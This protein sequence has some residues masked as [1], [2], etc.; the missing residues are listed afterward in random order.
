MLKR[1]ISLMITILILAQTVFVSGAATTLEELESE[2]L[3]SY[4]ENVASA[5]AAFAQS[6]R[7]DESDN[8]TDADIS[9]IMSMVF[10]ENPELFCLSHSYT[11]TY[12]RDQITGEALVRDVIFDYSMT[13]EEYGV[14]LTEVNAWVDNVTSLGDPAFSDY[15]WALFFHDY[16]CANYEYDGTLSSRSVYSFIKTGRGVCQAYAYAYMMLLERVGV[17]ASWASSAEMNHLWNLVKIDGEWYHV[18]VTWDDPVGIVP[19]V[20]RHGYFL[21]SDVAIST[22]A[23]AH[24]GWVSSYACTSDKYDAN[25]SSQAQSAYAYADG[26]W[27][28]VKDGDLYETQSPETEGKLF[29]ELDLMWFKWNSENTYYTGMYSAVVSFG[30]KLYV[31]TPD[32]ILRVDPATGKRKQAFN[33]SG[34]AGRVY[35]FSIDMGED[36]VSGAGLAGAAVLVNIAKSSSEEGVTVPAKLTFVMTGG[37]GDANGDGIVNLSDAS[38]ILKFI[39]KWDVKPDEVA[40]DTNND[41]IINVTDVSNILRYIVS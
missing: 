13:K 26:K 19:G 10:N 14:A 5:A 33:Y 28:F 30:G 23:K 37:S 17:E 16:L 35:G 38:L 11:F 27:F 25:K 29:A 15:E 41:G 32:S 21:L 6:Y 24:Y 1:T 12:I 18:D 40:S 3:M 20:A 4:A 31:S 9:A 34:D 2:R 36:R 8:I 39:A 22:E 7:F